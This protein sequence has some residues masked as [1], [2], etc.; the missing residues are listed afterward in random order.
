MARQCTDQPPLCLGRRLGRRHRSADQPDLCPGDGWRGHVEGRHRGRTGH[1]R[2]E[3]RPGG[4]PLAGHRQS[5]P[6]LQAQLRQP[7]RT[8]DVRGFIRAI[9]ERGPVAPTRPRNGSNRQGVDGEGAEPSEGQSEAWGQTRRATKA[10]D[11]HA[12]KPAR[13]LPRVEKILG[14]RGGRASTTQ[15]FSCLRPGLPGGPRCEKRLFSPMQ[16]CWS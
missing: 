6:G 1:Q 15:G 8:Q 7:H 16:K 10:V 5:L 2:Q 3:G 14:I 9:P 13:V 4:V 12:E 11:R